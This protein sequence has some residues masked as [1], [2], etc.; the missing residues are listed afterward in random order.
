MH[1]ILGFKHSSG[2]ERKLGQKIT[3]G[4]SFFCYFAAVVCA[5]MMFYLGME[6]TE[7]PVFASFMA[8]TV[9]F[10]CVG[11]VLHVLGSGNLPSL[12]V[13]DNPEQ[14]TYHQDPPSDE[15]NTSK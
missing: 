7:T 13:D 9:F 8:T 4:V 11:I 12:K 10:A 3:L 15:S 2:E 1:K 14:E 6:S 5:G